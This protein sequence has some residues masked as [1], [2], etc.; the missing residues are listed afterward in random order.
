[1][2]TKSSPIT[3]VIILML[4]CTVGLMQSSEAY[5]YMAYYSIAKHAICTFLIEELVS[6]KYLLT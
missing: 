5:K 1:M 4:E 2:A 6:N 3:C